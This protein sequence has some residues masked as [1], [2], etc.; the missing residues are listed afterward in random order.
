VTIFDETRPLVIEITDGGRRNIAELFNLDD[1]LGIP[2]IVFF[3]TYWIGATFHPVHTVRGEVISSPVDGFY[4]IPSADAEIEVLDEKSDPDLA[5]EL[6]RWKEYKVSDPIGMK[7][8]RDL[9]EEIVKDMVKSGVI[10]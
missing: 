9:A 3:D 8:T 4:D 5:D 2:G 10:S 1:F 6:R 7:A